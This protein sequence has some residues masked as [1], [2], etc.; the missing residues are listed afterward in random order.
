MSHFRPFVVFLTLAAAAMA[1]GAYFTPGP[2]YAA[3]EKPALTPPNWLFPV[4]WPILYLAMAIAA[5]LAWRKRPQITTV[6]PWLVQLVLNA[7]WSW[8]FFGLQRPA[9]AFLEITLLWIAIVVNI[10]VFYRIHKGAAG[11]LMPYLA[12]VSFASWLNWQLWHLNA[13]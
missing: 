3:L 6:A 13:P 10:V 11:L 4:V 9:L 2:W 5:T 12:W 1:F 8:L 7:L